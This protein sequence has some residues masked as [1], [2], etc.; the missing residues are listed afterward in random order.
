MRLPLFGATRQHGYIGFLCRFADKINGHLS[1]L[2]F[3]ELINYFP[4]KF[5]KQGFLNLPNPNKGYETSK[6]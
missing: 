2:L 4:K 6:S 5:E 3:G 1:L